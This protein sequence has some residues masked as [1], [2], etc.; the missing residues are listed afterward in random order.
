MRSVGFHANR[1]LGCKYRH[2]CLWHQGF[3]NPSCYA[4]RLLVVR[5]ARQSYD[6]NEKDGLLTPEYADCLLGIPFNFTAEPA[7]APVP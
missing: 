7:I 1:R 2:A 5:Y 3:W 6:L 4:N